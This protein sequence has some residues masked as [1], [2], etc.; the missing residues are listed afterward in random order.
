VEINRQ[1]I[2]RVVLLTKR[3]AFKFPRLVYG[4]EM[5]LNGLLANLSEQD[6]GNYH[7]AFLIPNPVI[8]AAPGGFCNVYRRA[9]QL[10]V[11]YQTAK[12][13]FDWSPYGDI[14]EEHLGVVNG[15]IVLLDYAMTGKCFS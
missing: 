13:W 5:F 7:D 10:P 4:W 2:T 12:Y 9:A 6:W 11:N 15:R 1:G 8:R 3:Y 14:K